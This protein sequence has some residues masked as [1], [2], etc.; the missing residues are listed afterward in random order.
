[1]EESLENK[2]QAASEALRQ[3]LVDR[4]VGDGLIRSP[5][6]EAAFRAVARHLF[7]PDI[8]IEEAY[9]DQAVAIKHIEGRAVSSASQPAMIAIMLEQL[10]LERGHRV[11]EIGA[12]SGYNAALIG[13]IVGEE[14]RVVTVDIDADLV[15]AAGEHIATAGFL[16]VA[17]V[18]ADGAEG[19]PPAAPYDRI[20]LTVGA[21]DIAPAWWAQLKPGGI[22][23]LPLSL[24]GPQ[25]AI[26]FR[27]AGDHLEG[28]SVRSCGFIRLR[29]A[30]AGPER[31]V[32]L[33]P[34]PGL[35]LFVDNRTPLLEEQLYKGLTMPYQEELLLKG[36]MPREVWD[37]LNLWIA[38]QDARYG[39]LAAEGQWA[40]REIVPEMVDSFS[41]NRARFTFG[42]FSGGS[43]AVLARVAAKAGKGAVEGDGAT[44]PF[45]IGVRSFGRD[46]GLTARIVELVGAWE[47]RGRPMTDRLRVRAYP[48][49]GRYEA[50]AG[51]AV[52]QKEWW[53]L[54]VDWG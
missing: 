41:R 20:I 39:E 2:G 44:Q 37:G 11:L 29:G 48:S 49:E 8:P 1:M 16:N 45:G 27:H 30:F 38:A 6:V 3:T 22:I 50:T 43:G 35:S 53:R 34:E 17:A 32:S 24:N 52:I 23:V 12:G 26:A 7:V 18:T 10:Q 5:L 33:G 28:L 40:E 13:H 14:G 51:E 31:V 4:L 54:V 21:W 42:I 15:L 19:Y 9:R 46:A 25:E 36:V 47:K